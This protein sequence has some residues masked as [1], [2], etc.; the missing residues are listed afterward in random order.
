MIGVTHSCRR[1]ALANPWVLPTFC[2]A[3]GSAAL[4]LILILTLPLS[5]WWLNYLGF[6]PFV[7]AQAAFWR[8][9]RVHKP[10][11]MYR[12]W[13]PGDAPRRSIAIII[14]RRHGSDAEGDIR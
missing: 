10:G 2:A 4:S 6:I 3:I 12:T 14:L 9:R 13:V 7:S 11:D 1:C 8:W 5:V